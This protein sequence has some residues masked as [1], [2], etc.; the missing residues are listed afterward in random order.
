MNYN[1]NKTMNTLKKIASAE[2]KSL[3]M[4]IDENL[5]VKEIQLI[6]NIVFLE[7]EGRNT[8]SLLAK[9][10]TFARSAI[11]TVLNK[12]EDKGYI[13]R[14]HDKIDRRK[15]YVLPIGK[16]K[17]VK[18]K[19]IEYYSNINKKLQQ[20]YTKEELSTFTQVLKTLEGY[21]K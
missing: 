3:V 11:S 21:I 6:I 14:K 1:I 5:L 15:V 20:D 4:F 19:Y 7:K 17:E 12:L 9:E 2:E 13:E 8:T 16:S 18:D 10:L